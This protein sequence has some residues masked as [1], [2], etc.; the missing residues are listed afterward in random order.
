MLI[1]IWGSS[2]YIALGSDSHPPDEFNPPIALPKSEGTGV[3]S[4]KGSSKRSLR[5]GVSS[6]AHNYAG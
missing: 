3:E 4:K 6:I 2:I 1:N 5:Y